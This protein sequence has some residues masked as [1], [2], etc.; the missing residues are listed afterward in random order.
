MFFE[1]SV[2]VTKYLVAFVRKFN[3]KNFKKS[4]N[5][6]TLAFTIEIWINLGAANNRT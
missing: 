2:E 4:T 1:R 3:A 6:V 5:L